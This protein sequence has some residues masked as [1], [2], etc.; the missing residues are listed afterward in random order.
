[1]ATT[2]N[3]PKSDIVPRLNFQNQMIDKKCHNSDT[4]IPLI[5]L[6]RKHLQSIGVYV[7]N[8]FGQPVRFRILKELGSSKAV[9]CVVEIVYP[10]KFFGTRIGIPRRVVSENPVGFSPP[11]EGRGG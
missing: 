11:T 9:R 6:T 5:P 3:A 8:F 2:L 7:S 1:M 4:F 10:D